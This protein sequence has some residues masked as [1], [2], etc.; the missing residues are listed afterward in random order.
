MTRLLAA[1]DGVAYF[2]CAGTAELAYG[3][4]GL[5]LGDGDFT[6]RVFHGS[7]HFSGSRILDLAA[8]AFDGK[9][10]ADLDPGAGADIEDEGSIRSSVGDQPIDGDDFRGQ[11]AGLGFQ[12]LR[13][14]VNG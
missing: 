14:L 9:A 1:A 3:R 8:E 13:G 5:D 6:K 10:I 12:L 4:P 11:G 2:W 7:Q